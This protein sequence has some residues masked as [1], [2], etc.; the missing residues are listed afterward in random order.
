[1]SDPSRT[2]QTP[3]AR[4]ASIPR[5]ILIALIPVLAGALAAGPTAAQA[6]RPDVPAPVT[7]IP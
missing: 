3:M 7:D 6:T 2:L 1:M 5:T 4:I